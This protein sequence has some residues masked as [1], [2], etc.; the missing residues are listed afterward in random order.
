[1][2]SALF[3]LF[4]ITI[5][6]VDERIEQLSKW[7]FEVFTTFLGHNALKRCKEPRLDIMMSDDEYELVQIAMT[8]SDLVTDES[9][10][11]CLFEIA[12]ELKLR[13]KH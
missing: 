3:L 7:K 9:Q 10:V 8:S 13:M 6:C 2:R 11:F 4:V 12:D 5:R 1:M